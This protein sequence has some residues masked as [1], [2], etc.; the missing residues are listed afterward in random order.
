[1]SGILDSLAPSPPP[2]TPIERPAA[3]DQETAAQE[4]DLLRLR[5]ERRRGIDSLKIDPGVRSA[6]SGDGLSSG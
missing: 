2:V 3:D 5:A 4:A 6:G 1:M